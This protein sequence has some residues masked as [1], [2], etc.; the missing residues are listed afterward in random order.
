M[1]EGIDLLESGRYK[2]AL[3]VFEEITE[4]YPNNGLMWR[5][6]GAALGKLGKFNEA[7][8]AF[9][10]AIEL[11][12]KDIIAWHNKVLALTNLGRKEEAKEAEAAEKRAK[13]E[14]EFIA[15]A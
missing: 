11:D 8:D 3:K 1:Q 10:K 13:L 12:P 15:K 5:K 7:L 2:Q 6:R 14:K 9:S 4:L